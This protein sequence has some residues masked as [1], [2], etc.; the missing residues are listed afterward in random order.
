MPDDPA[1][2]SRPRKRVTEVVMGRSRRMGAEGQI[3]RVVMAW[4]A[5]EQKPAEPIRL[6]VLW[7]Q[8]NWLEGELT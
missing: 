7:P 8:G 1:S 3:E 4:G 5:M 6:R 2:Q